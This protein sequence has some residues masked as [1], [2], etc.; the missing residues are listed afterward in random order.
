VT[1]TIDLDELHR[2]EVAA[3]ENF[4]AEFEAFNPRPVKPE[5]FS[6][7]SLGIEFPIAVITGVAAIVQAAMRTGYKFFDLAS[8][9]GMGVGS[10][11]DGASAMIGVEG[12]I[13]VVGF[14]MARQRGKALIA[15]GELKLTRW[16]QYRTWGGLV[17]ALTISV[18]TGFAQS[19]T[20]SKYASLDFQK[21]VDWMVVVALGLGASLLAWL[22]GEI[23]GQ[24]V[25]RAEMLYVSA[26][27]NFDKKLKEWKEDLREAWQASDQYKLLHVDIQGA[28]K[29]A[30]AGYV[31]PRGAKA[32]RSFGDASERTN[33]KALRVLAYL[34]EH[35][36]PEFVPGATE[37]AAACSVS[38]SY[39]S[40][41]T[42]GWIAANP[43]EKRKTASHN[44]HQPALE[45]SGS[46][47]T[48]DASG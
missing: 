45:V 36:T 35:A 37:V 33:A 30:K 43:P 27:G 34:D 17:V 9:Q 10:W 20:G 46:D 29:L 23:I 24:L 22:A 38:K 11:L 32:V 28:L 39:A 8:K 41:V 14:L 1:Q 12:F 18:A 44:G 40:E 15:K 2:K 7:K 3:R 13:A 5:R 42:K 26:T 21:F 47:E 31:I 4:E 16:E 48:A 25:V 6:V 19:I